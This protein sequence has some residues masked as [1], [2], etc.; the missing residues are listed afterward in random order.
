ML[1]ILITFAAIALPICLYLIYRQRLS[2]SFP[3]PP[4]PPRDPIIGHLRHMPSTNRAAVFHEW[5][6]TYGDVMYLEVLGNP[7]IVLNT[8]QVAAEL[9]NKRSAIYS[10]RPRFILYEMIRWSTTLS[11]MRY[12]KRFTLHRQLHQSYLSRHN[13]LEFRDMQ[14]QE[15]H[16]LVENLLVAP[17]IGV[18]QVYQQRT[19]ALRRFS[20]GVISQIVAG[21]RICTDDDPYMQTTQ[22]LRESL[23]RAGIPG[24]TALDL[25]PFH[26]FSG[27]PI[28]SGAI[29]R[30]CRPALQR[31]YDLPLQAVRAQMIW[32]SV[33]VFVLA[34]L[35]H[36]EYQVKAQQEIDS[37]VGTAARLPG[38]EDRGQLPLVECIM[39]ETL[40][41]LPCLRTSGEISTYPQRRPSLIDRSCYSAMSLDERTYSTP[42]QFFSERFL[43]ELRG[44]GEPHFPSVYGFGRRICSGQHLADQSLWIVIV[45]IL[46]NCTISTAFDENGCAIVLEASMSDGVSSHPDDFPCIISP[47][48]HKLGPA[49]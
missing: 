9:L 2:N 47:R 14:T 20:T 8:E 38:F 37:V 21:H 32:S 15:A 46:A 27:T 30:E 34:M 18:Q 36:P 40:R 43:P 1:L 7:I 23:G 13:C 42:K 28:A 45:S 44:R 35:L 16:S 22:A 4:G 5:S 39:Q 31:L 12:G 3:L 19:S 24:V 41:G 26:M 48:D 49:E 10:D 25:F 29:A 33:T 17:Y 6:K 11:L